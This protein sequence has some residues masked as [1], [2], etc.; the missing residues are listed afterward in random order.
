MADIK[1][2]ELPVK[3]FTMSSRDLIEVSESSMP[4]V[5]V[6]KKMSTGLLVETIFGNS[7]F[8]AFSDD[9][10]QTTVALNPKPMDIRQNTIMNGVSMEA[11]SG[12]KVAKAGYY[13]I[14]FSAQLYRT[15]GG[16]SAHVD[17]WLRIDGADV[18]AST[19]KV[20][21]NANSVYQVA[22]WNW[23]VYMNAD[24]YAEIIWSPTDSRIQLQAEP[25][26]FGLPC[27]AIP[28]VIITINRVG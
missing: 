7:T 3:G 6:S 27:P 26:D 14:Q 5:F 23:L 28:S 18:P 13:N 15:A 4:G 25:E 10:T 16:T 24:Q 12:I 9:A 1:I 22:A 11:S 8:G 17:I 21:V 20:N 19:T 2:S